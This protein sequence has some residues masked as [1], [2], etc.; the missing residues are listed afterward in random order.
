MYEESQD[1]PY[2]FYRAVGAG[3]R[4]GQLSHRSM[5]FHQADPCYSGAALSVFYFWTAYSLLVLAGV[6]LAWK[7]MRD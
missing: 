6:L 1:A 4:A 2:R 3:L 5:G 7:V